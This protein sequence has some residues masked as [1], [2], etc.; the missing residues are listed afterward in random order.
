MTYSAFVIYLEH[1]KRRPLMKNIRY[2]LL[3]A[4]AALYVICN[5]FLMHCFDLSNDFSF[6]DFSFQKVHLFEL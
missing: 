6:N 1:V 2:V 5:V 3:D 4:L